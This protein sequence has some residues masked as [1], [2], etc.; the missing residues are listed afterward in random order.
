[1]MDYF[2]L[3]SFDFCLVLRTGSTSVDNATRRP[4]ARVIFP[5]PGLNQRFC[6]KVSTPG[7][8]RGR[9]A[10]SVPASG[11]LHSLIVLTVY[12]V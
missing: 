3:M 6:G 9:R 11:L 1:M 12:G 5:L 8:K 2:N 7:G 4:G 10:C